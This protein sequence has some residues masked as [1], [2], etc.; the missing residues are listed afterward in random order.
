MHSTVYMY[1]SIAAIRIAKYKAAF[2]KLGEKCTNY[3][4]Y[5]NCFYYC[6]PVFIILAGF[7]WLVLVYVNTGSKCTTLVI[8]F[9]SHLNSIIVNLLFLQVYI[10]LSDILLSLH[11]INFVEH[12][13]TSF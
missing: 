5:K 11:H 3:K 13:A 7:I 6:Q 9:L 2:A 10:N 1:F 8:I 4:R 12:T